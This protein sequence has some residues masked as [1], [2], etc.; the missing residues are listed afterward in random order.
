VAPK[1]EEDP[2]A[3]HGAAERAG[4]GD[5]VAETVCKDRHRLAETGHQI[6]EFDAVRRLRE[7]GFRLRQARTARIRS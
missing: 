3:G 4:L 1:L 7:R 6:F 2:T 5:A